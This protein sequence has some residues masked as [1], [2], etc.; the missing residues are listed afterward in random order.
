MNIIVTHSEPLSRFLSRLVNA[1]GQHFSRRVPAGID[2]LPTTMRP[3][4][5]RAICPR[6][7]SGCRCDCCLKARRCLAWL[8][9]VNLS[10]PRVSETTTAVEIPIGAVM[11]CRRRMK[12][13]LP[14]WIGF[15]RGR[16]AG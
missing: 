16:K 14:I 9:I 12:I 7:R 1:Q 5:S 10:G 4:R 6:R 11:R 2:Q 13:W 8:N 3:C 15:I